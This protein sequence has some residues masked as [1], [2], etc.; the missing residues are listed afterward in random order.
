M[1]SFIVFLLVSFVGILFFFLGLIIGSLSARVRQSQSSD[2][3]TDKLLESVKVDETI[4]FNIEKHNMRDEESTY[5]FNALR[6]DE[7]N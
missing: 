4:V 3:F 6:R 7:L 1:A 5:G 2:S